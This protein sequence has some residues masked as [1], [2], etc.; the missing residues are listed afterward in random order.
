MWNINCILSVKFCNNDVVSLKQSICI[1][2]HKEAF[3]FHICLT[4]AKMN[5]VRIMKW[6]NLKYIFVLFME[7]NLEENNMR[8]WRSSTYCISITSD[9]HICSSQVYLSNTL[10]TCSNNMVAYPRNCYWNLIKKFGTPN[11]ILHW[12]S[13]IST[14]FEMAL[15]KRF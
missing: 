5:V 2:S 11:F 13:N 12:T 15:E 6:Q 7:V 10:I 14:Q 3:S 8:M 9:V 4:L 1:I